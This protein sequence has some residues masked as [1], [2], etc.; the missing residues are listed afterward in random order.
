[1][2]IKRQVFDTEITITLTEEE[3]ER[4]YECVRKK[5]IVEEVREGLE[6]IDDL[7]KRCKFPYPGISYF[8]E[9]AIQNLEKAI[10][11]DEDFLYK[12]YQHQDPYHS[13]LAIARKGT[14]AIREKSFLPS[15]LVSTN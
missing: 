3:M 9:E 12:M 7:A 1:M 10:L 13:I 6:G 5:K 14:R 4:V 8:S 15:Q 11:S 2:K